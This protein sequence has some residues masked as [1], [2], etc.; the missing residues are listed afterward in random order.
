MYVT[1]TLRLEVG[2]SQLRQAMD[3]VQ[4]EMS[5][6]DGLTVAT[7]AASEAQGKFGTD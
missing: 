5:R 4:E 1:V 2:V 7:K 3:G 6:L